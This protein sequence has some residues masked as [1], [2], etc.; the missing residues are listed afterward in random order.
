MTKQ[1]FLAMSLPYRLKVYVK[2]NHNPDNSEL[3]TMIGIVDDCIIT[4]THEEDI[5][6]LADSNYGLCLRPLSDL[7]KP[8]EHKGEKFVPI[9]KLREI[10]G[11]GW[12]DVYERAVERMQEWDIDTLKDK[13][14]YLPFEFIQIFISWHFDLADLISKGE[15]IDV[16]TLEKNPYK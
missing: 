16:N 12:C 15:A 10:I 11:D 8:I 2:Y 6:P 5:A 9:E 1:E 4:D 7:T 3:E 13:I 14:K